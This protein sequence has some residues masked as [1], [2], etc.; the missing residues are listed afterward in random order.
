MGL[1]S[2]TAVVLLGCAIE[3]GLDEAVLAAQACLVGLVAAASVP[4][5]F[6]RSIE[7]GY[8]LSRSVLT[9]I[10]S[11]LTVTLALWWLP[12]TGPAGCVAGA[13]LGVLAATVVAQRSRFEEA[14]ESGPRAAKAGATRRLLLTRVGVPGV[15][16]AAIRGLRWLAGPGWSGR[17]ITFPGGSLA[18]LIATFLEDGPVTAGRLATA[19][20]GGSFATLAFLAVF[21]ASAPRHGFAW[22]LLLG[23]VAALCALLVPASLGRW[24]RWPR[25]VLAGRASVWIVVRVTVAGPARWMRADPKTRGW[26]APSRRCGATR[27]FAPRLE[28]LS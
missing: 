1:P 5:A 25:R 24:G 27:R 10:A 8:T 26:L 3:R 15:Y 21:R 13:V 6:A 20:P 16:V 11:Y 22:A 7:A 12:G 28:C 14:D 19:M 17:F 9:G 23:Y 18:L 4:V 2:T